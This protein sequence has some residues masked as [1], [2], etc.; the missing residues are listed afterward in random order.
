MDCGQRLGASS[1]G[2]VARPRALQQPANTPSVPL[3]SSTHARAQNHLVPLGPDAAGDRV[4]GRFEGEYEVA[5]GS[6]R[7]LRLPRDLVVLEL[8]AQGQAQARPGQLATAVCLQECRDDALVPAAGPRCATPPPPGGGRRGGSYLRHGLRSEHGRG[9]GGVAAAERRRA[10]DECN[11][12]ARRPCGGGGRA[13]A[14]RRRRPC[15]AGS[16]V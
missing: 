6:V 12:S 15:A 10:L 16:V 9:R 7:V 5:D 4:L 13:G 14:G 11:S 3:D 1:S 8:E 2:Q